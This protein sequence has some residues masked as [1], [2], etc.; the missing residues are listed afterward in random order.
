MAKHRYNQT[1][2]NAIDICEAIKANGSGRFRIVWVK[3]KTWGHNPNVQYLGITVGR[4]SGCGYD[5]ESAALVEFLRFLA[6]DSNVYDAS[7]AGFRAVVRVLDEAGW[8]L[9]KTYSGKSED[10]YSITRK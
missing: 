6:P 7:G 4:A 3:S 10:G 9:E 1:E 5:K 8:T 2:R